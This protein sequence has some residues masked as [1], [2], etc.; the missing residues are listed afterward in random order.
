MPPKMDVVW[1]ED[2][3]QRLARRLDEPF[4][5]TGDPGDV[6]MA[7]GRRARELHYGYVQCVRGDL[8]VASRALLRP[9]V[10]VNIL[11]RFIR[12]RPEHRAKLWQ[13]ET[14]RQM[15][16]LV[17][18]IKRRPIPEKQRLDLPSDDELVEARRRVADVRKEAMDAGVPGLTNNGPLIP[19]LRGQVEMLDT[20]EAWQAYVMAYGPLSSEQHIGHFSFQQSFLHELPD[21]TVVHHDRYEVRQLE[22]ALGSSVFASTLI[23]VSNWLA[24]GITAEAERIRVGLVGI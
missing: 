17:E 20:S 14:N 10:E 21:G 15:V 6:C 24:L 13:H 3:L 23:V 12:G 2:E 4:V 1:A 16:E 22:R 9:A 19:P 5:S 8:I 11:L 7:L 18:D